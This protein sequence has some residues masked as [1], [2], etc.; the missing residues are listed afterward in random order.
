MTSI[1]ANFLP[2]LFEQLPGIVIGTAGLILIHTRWKRAHPR[3]HLYGSI[4]LA[5]LLVNGL[6]R[7]LSRT[8]IHAAYDAQTL[9]TVALVNK[10]TMANLT[11]FVVFTASLVFILVAILADRDSVKSS[12]GAA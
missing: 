3:A 1:V 8:Y 6:W 10:S 2:H 5:L 7:A 4:G 11:G 12:R 9:T